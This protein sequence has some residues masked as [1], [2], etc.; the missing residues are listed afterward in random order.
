[1]ISWYSHLRRQHGLR[2]TSWFYLRVLRARFLH[3][4]R[5]TL[6]GVKVECPCCGWTGRRFLDYV[7]LGYSV[8]AA[9]CPQCESHSRHHNEGQNRHRGMDEKEEHQDRQNGKWLDQA[10]AEDVHLG[11]LPGFGVGTADDYAG[12]ACGAY[13]ILIPECDYS[14]D[15]VNELGLEGRRSGTRLRM[16]A[17][18]AR[19]RSLRSQ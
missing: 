17:E 6:P 5:N 8:P 1:M 11:R 2:K 9:V 15:R 13:I 10:V 14:I 19:V 3:T 12:E 4:L 7:D 18:K 16:R